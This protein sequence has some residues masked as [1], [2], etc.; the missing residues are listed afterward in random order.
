VK[1]TALIV[2]LVLSIIVIL[3]SC[4][5]GF[6]AAVGEAAGET[7]DAES[8]SSAG[9]FA[10]FGA[11]LGFIGSGLVIKYQK[12]AAVLFAITALILIIAGFSTIYKDMAVY[13]FLMIIPLIFSV[14][15]LKKETN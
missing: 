6:G 7:E 13:G 9:G 15:A 11:I 10:F 5:A 8:L 14:V 4:F 12:A 2:G 3:S 1:I